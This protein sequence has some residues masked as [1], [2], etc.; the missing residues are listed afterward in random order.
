MQD[1]KDIGKAGVSKPSLI[2]ADPRAQ[3]SIMIVE[4]SEL[5]RMICA[6][7]VRK[8]QPEA[9]CKTHGSAVDALIALSDRTAPMPD[10]ILLDVNLPELNGFEFLERASLDL[11]LLAKTSI[12]LMTSAP[13][14]SVMRRMV[15]KYS[16]CIGEVEKPVT[17]DTIRSAL[18]KLDQLRAVSYLGR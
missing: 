10:L 12:L 11:R 9:D 3:L 14:P 7:A 17:A 4:D 18:R 16:L 6:R 15:A 5:D 2:A 8:A 1:S 13:L